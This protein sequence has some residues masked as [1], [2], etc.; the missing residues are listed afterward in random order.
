MFKKLHQIHGQG[1]GRGLAG[2]IT[3]GFMGYARPLALSIIMEWKNIGGF[4]QKGNMIV[5]MFRKYSCEI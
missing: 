5:L 3:H 4:E 1:A 2:H